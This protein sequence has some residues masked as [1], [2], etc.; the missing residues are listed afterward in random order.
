MRTRVTRH[1][2]MTF[3]M[4][5]L[6]LPLEIG[7]GYLVRALQLIPDSGKAPLWVALLFALP[8]VLVPV[9]GF[10]STF[11]NLRC[12]SCE[13]VVAFQVSA[14]YSAFGIWASRTCRHCGT[15]IFGEQQQAR[16]GRFL[17]IMV[18]VGVVVALLAGVGALASLHH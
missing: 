2:L 1:F 13:K 7:I 10:Y 11:T 5:A 8:I 17:L 16:R 6:A 14:N 12:P 3:G 18:A 15:Q 9:V 4:F